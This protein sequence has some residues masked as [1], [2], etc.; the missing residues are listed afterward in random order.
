M[1]F[2]VNIIKSILLGIVEGITEWLPVSS[3]GHMILFDEFLTLKVNNDF[4]E[5]F[6]V[7]IQLGA[8]LAVVIMFWKKL[9]PFSPKSTKT[10]NRE[11]WSTWFK[12]LVASLPAGILGFAFDDKIDQMLTGD[13]RVLIVSSALVLY[14][15]LF[16]VI[17]KFAKKPKITT[18]NDINYKTALLMGAFQALSLIP[19]TSRSGSTILGGILIG[20]SRT[21]AAEFS[22]F[23][24]IPA[25]VG[26]S[27]IKLLK[28]F[29]NGNSISLQ[30]GVI[31]LAGMVTAFVVSM[32]CINFLMNYIRKHD[33][34]LF[35]WYRIALGA[36][37]LL[38]I[39]FKVL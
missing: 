14:G 15:V 2:F 24:S 20:C 21:A 38:L 17:E 28:Y 29:V 7:V 11:I 31:L 34:K 6:L 8:I 4:K 3:T 25:M 22:F 35:G 9:W 23:M 37:L 16:I 36:L 19:G 12:V 1:E 32:L 5:L 33:F 26:G 18:S 39:A 27:G 10:E 13:L 30:E